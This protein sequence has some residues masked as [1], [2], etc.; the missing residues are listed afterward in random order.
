MSEPDEH[1]GII[2]DA[3][4]YLDDAVSPARK[5]EIDAHL[6]ICTSCRAEVAKLRE[7]V[8]ALSGL[9]RVEAPALPDE[10]AQTIHRRS[11]GRFFGR[12]TFGDRVPFELVAIV[13]LILA[14]LAIWSIRSSSPPATPPPQAAPPPGSVLPRPLP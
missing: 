7:A 9:K 6:A 10:V 12:R 5:A 1:E 2:A 14:A 4:D 8:S 11:G 3:S 13:G